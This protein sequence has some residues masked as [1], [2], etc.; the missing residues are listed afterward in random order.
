MLRAEAG[1]KA[2]VTYFPKGADGM[3]MPEEHNPV[4]TVTLGTASVVGTMTRV[5]VM[6]VT[7][8]W[9]LVEPLVGIVEYGTQ[10]S[11]ELGE[12]QA[13][14]VVFVCFGKELGYV[15][16]H[17]HVGLQE[18]KRE[19]ESACSPVGLRITL[20]ACSHGARLTQ[21]GWHRFR[22][23]SPSSLRGSPPHPCPKEATAPASSCQRRESWA[24]LGSYRR[25]VVEE[26]LGFFLQQIREL[27]LVQVVIYGVFYGVLVVDIDETLQG[28]LQVGFHLAKKGQATKH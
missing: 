22:K 10:R 15:L 20:A 13:P 4:G 26:G 28:E 23:T 9:M 2:L 3:M 17:G 6:A 11:Q 19:K 25:G 5:I 12:L 24:T 8:I 21:Q 1:D 18:D 14:I 16:V 27:R 7:I